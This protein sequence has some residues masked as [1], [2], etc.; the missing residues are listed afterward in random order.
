MAGYQSVEINVDGGVVEA[1]FQDRGATGKLEVRIELQVGDELT[2]TSGGASRAW[3]VVGVTYEADM[4]Y[5]WAQ[6][7]AVN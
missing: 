4:S 1:L 7:E 3:R 2:I 6:L 5:S